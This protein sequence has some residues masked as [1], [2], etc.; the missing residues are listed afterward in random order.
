VS[1]KPLNQQI[2]L[3]YQ[4]GPANH[5]THLEN[6]AGIFQAG[7]LRSY[8]LMR[9]QSYF[10]LSN[11]DVQ[12]GRA[13]I[14]IPATGKPLHD[15]VPLYFGFKTPMVAWNQQH[16][17][18]LVFL[19]FSLDILA[20]PGV[21]V[22]DGNAR[23]ENTRFRLYRGLDDLDFLDSKAIQT[24]KYAHDAELKRR[25]Q[26]ELLVPDVLPVAEVLDLICFSQQSA[27]GVVAILQKSGIKKSVIVNQGWYFVAAPTDGGKA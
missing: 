22:S 17:D 6:L 15:Y 9:G 2:R 12:S 19:R 13:Q 10:N 26:A 16:N 21:V 25:K 11:Q 14:V 4:L 18:A 5:M 24:V 27:R 20:R 7:E 1:D 3:R 8:N 23:A